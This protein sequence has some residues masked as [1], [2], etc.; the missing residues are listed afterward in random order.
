[1]GVCNGTLNLLDHFCPRKKTKSKNFY[2]PRH[3]LLKWKP[4]H[5]SFTTTAVV[6]IIS[7][8][9]R[10]LHATTHWS[11][12]AALAMCLWKQWTRLDCRYLLEAVASTTCMGVGLPRPKT[13]MVRIDSSVYAPRLSLET[14]V[15]YSYCIHTVFFKITRALLFS[16]TKL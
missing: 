13:K 5:R 1:M 9:C 12:Q 16:T 8:S 3:S 7:R 2:L 4:R 10:R 6:A 14:N 11:H 15:A